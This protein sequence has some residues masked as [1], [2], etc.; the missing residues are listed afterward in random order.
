VESIP[1]LL[2]HMEHGY[3]IPIARQERTAA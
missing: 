3:E 1:E 2:N